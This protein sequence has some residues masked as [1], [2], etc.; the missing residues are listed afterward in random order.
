MP[1]NLN[2][3]AKLAFYASRERKGDSLRL[4]KLTGF[5]VRFVNYVRSNGRNVN[6]PLANAMYNISRRRMKNS[7]LIS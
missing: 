2:K 3:D 7:E 5:T 1:R 6:Q 4:S